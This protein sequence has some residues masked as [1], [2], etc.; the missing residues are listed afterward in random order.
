MTGPHEITAYVCDDN[1]RSFH[2]SVL[3]NQ[4]NPLV[5]PRIYASSDGGFV[6]FASLG[7]NESFSLVYANS[8]DGVTW[9]PFSQFGPASSSTNPFV[10]YLAPFAGGDIVVY[11]AQYVSATRLS[12][13]LF[14]TVS[15]NNLR[16][17]TPPVL[18]TDQ[19]T[20][21][22]NS[23]SAFYNY[24]NQRPFVLSSGGNLYLAC[25]NRQTQSLQTVSALTA[26]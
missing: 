22:S 5:A 19:Q 14:S 11:Q 21:P 9:S 18:V 12:Y 13:Q 24:N 26:R 25:T 2:R 1:G 23:T 16:S 17:W 15:T 6:I 8:K 10:P 3:S 20:L 7:Q 4:N